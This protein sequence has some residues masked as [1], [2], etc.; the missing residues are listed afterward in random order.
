PWDRPSEAAERRKAL[1]YNVS[2][3][4]TLAIGVA[5]MYAILF[6]LALLA[7]A[8]L[9]DSG[10]LAQT[11]GHPVG[12]GSYLNLVWLCSSVGIV[13]GALGSSLEDEETV[14]S[15]T[16]SRREQERQERNQRRQERR[17]PANRNASAQNSA[18]DK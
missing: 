2:T 3:V 16:Y 6:V 11:L 1:L 7:A 9:I 10:Y 15:A 4:T 5:C 12:V 8:V 14:R 18:R 17:R 13:A